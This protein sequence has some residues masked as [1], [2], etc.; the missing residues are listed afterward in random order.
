M[1]ELYLKVAKAMPGDLNRGVAR[2][3]QHILLE[4]KLSAGDVIE[5][6]GKRATVARIF[7]PG[8]IV[9]VEGKRSNMAKVWRTEKQD[10]SQEVIRVD[11]FT[12]QNADVGI[13][14][15]VKVRR[16]ITKDAQMVML[17][18]MD[19]VSVNLSGNLNIAEIIRHQISKRAIMQGDIVPLLYSMPT[20]ILGKMPTNQDVQLVA[21]RVEP[22][23]PV[24]ITDTTVIE[25]VE[26]PV[27]VSNVRSGIVKYNDIGGLADVK[28]EI[29][30]TIEWSLKNPERFIEMGI[31]PPK[32]I[33][34]FGPSGTGK[35]QL[36]KAIANESGIEFFSISGPEIL[37]RSPEDSEARLKEVFENAKENAPAIIFI[38]ELDS[39]AIR[40]DDVMG[41]SERR[42]VSQM[43]SLMDLYVERG[44]VIVIGS[45]NR[46][47]LIDPALL[48]PG[49]FDRLI[50]VEPP[51][52]DARLE[53]FKI[54]SRKMPLTSDVDLLKLA[55]LTDGLVGSD[56]EGI[57][58][59]AVMLAFRDNPNAQQ[60]D[61]KHFREALMKFKH[62]N[63]MRMNYS[64]GVHEKLSGQV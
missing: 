29:I 58:R 1:K 36:V 11:S 33:L 42:V 19:G 35:T 15:R 31:R 22:P 7:S 57:C 45:T 49:R 34:L 27:H 43:F 18:P 6:E 40:R 25:L 10:L 52:R 51:T 60:V 62:N 56:I 28:R 4:L 26:K 55:G 47:D 37:S 13:G 46:P 64:T 39:V 61:M 12:R 23:G 5:I 41:E 17:A 50:Y 38:D 2:I 44:K 16:A 32:S 14:E 48:R 53:I 54:H 3:D 30:E 59:E 63:D 20:P 21:V 8:D 24:V 9:E